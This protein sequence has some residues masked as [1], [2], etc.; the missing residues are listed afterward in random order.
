M[1]KEPWHDNLL[2]SL[3]ILSNIPLQRRVWVDGDFDICYII[4][5]A[6]LICQVFD[7]CFPEDIQ[8]D[9]ELISPTADLVLREIYKITCLRKLDLDRTPEDLLSDPEWI[10]V[11]QLAK[12]AYTKVKDAFSK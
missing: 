5:P 10:R 2:E 4:S 7:F 1:K 3:E 11:S 6:E 12:D 9:T 8:K